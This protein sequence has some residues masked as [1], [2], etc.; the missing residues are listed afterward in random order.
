VI[1]GR[2]SSDRTRT[3][4]SS[5]LHHDHITVHRTS[6]REIT[7]VVKKSSAVVLCVCVA[8]QS[9]HG[10]RAETGGRSGSTRASGSPGDHGTHQ[11]HRS[12]HHARTP[13]IRQPPAAPDRHRSH[14]S[15]QPN[16]IS[17]PI[18]EQKDTNK[19]GIFFSSAGDPPGT[20]QLP[21]PADSCKAMGPGLGVF[22]LT[23]D[24]ASVVSI[25][26]FVALLCA[27]IVLGHLLEENRWVNESMTALIIVSEPNTPPPFPQCA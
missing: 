23:S 26:L 13:P 7:G 6:R 2:K 5:E 17:I 10:R 16:S 14:S 19:V 15:T 20:P 25:N 12:E 24:H 18:E 22:G 11:L 21:P 1:K 4:D 27:C 8:E 3:F 9:R